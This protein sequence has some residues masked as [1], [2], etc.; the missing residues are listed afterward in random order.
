M[1]G[2]RLHINI[3]HVATVRNARGVPYP[4]PV[5]AA[6]TC[7]AAG[8]DGITA[9]L[10]EDRRH[11][12]DEDV[13]R[14]RAAIGSHFNLEM[15]ATDEMIAIAARVRPD[16]ITLVPERR[17]ERTTEGGLDVAGQRGPIE[18]CTAMARERGIR[19]SLFIAPEEGAVDLAKEIGVAQVELHTG[20]YCHAFADRSPAA[21]R[22]ELARIVRAAHRAHEAGI[23][24]A[25]GHGLTRHNVA[26]IVAVPEIVEV[27]IGHSVIADAIFLGLSGAVRELRAAIERGRG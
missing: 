18:K 13:E 1:P 4:D 20:E 2:V 22:E 10:R 26:E 7:E 15:A 25:A 3:D 17:E 6:Q 19:M 16:T 21:R 27:N 12:R 9:H 8:A 24:V 5:F 14:L 11:I 23:E